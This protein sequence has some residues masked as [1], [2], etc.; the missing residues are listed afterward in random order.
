MGHLLDGRDRFEKTPREWLPFGQQVGEICN[1]WADRNDIVA[2]VGEGAGQGIATA[3]WAPASAEM[4]IN[5]SEA[6]GE[7]ITPELVDDF[8]LRSTHFEFPA[9]AG[10]ALHEA[11]HARHTKFPLMEMFELRQKVKTFAVSYLIEWFEETRIEARGVKH[12]PK[13]RAFLRACALKLS[14]SDM[15]ETAERLKHADAM[16]MS[17]LILLSLARVDAGVLDA[18]DVKK[19]Q[20]VVEDTLGTDLLADLRRIWVKAQ[21][22]HGDTDMKP[23]RKL[24]ER[25]VKLLEDAG[26]KTEPE[27]VVVTAGGAPGEDGDGDGGEA[28]G[29]MAGAV[30]EATEAMEDAAEATEVAAGK[31]ANDQAGKERDEA[32][33]KAAA[34]AAKERSDASDAASKVFGA[35][36]G[37]SSKR[38]TSSY[39]YKERPPTA[40]ERAAAVIISRELERAR[41]RDRWSTKVSSQLPPGRMSGRGAMLRDVQR[42][43]G[44]LATAEPFST[45]RRYHTEDPRLTMA[46]MTDVS[47]SMSS[48][49]EPMAVTNYVMSEAGHRVQAR[50]ASVYYG[51][52]VFPGL[53]PGQRMDQVQIFRAPDSTERFNLAFKAV[54]GALDLLNST[55]ARLLVIVSDMI[56][57]GGEVVALRRWVKRCNDA[58]VAVISLPASGNTDSVRKHLKGLDYQMVEGAM[59]PVSVATRI[60][61]AAAEELTKAGTRARA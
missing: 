15:D 52:S 17:K 46:L 30:A 41:Y 48:A 53:R 5:V 44:Q 36:T 6:F 12:W 16:N 33:A 1:T 32:A 34:E 49:M 35:S 2:F 38:R 11:M 61:R 3:C 43:R 42:G 19:I 39:L 50:V 60:G 28:P 20:T 25:W 58:G 8:T 31:E 9:V 37:E 29:G 10:A 18:D 4:E 7:G 47:G 26:H 57:T 45:R 51:D 14:L 27:V 23:L 21:S 13:N 40:S 55:G 54:D 24:A 59:N 56:Y 22:H